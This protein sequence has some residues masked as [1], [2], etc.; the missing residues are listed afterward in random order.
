MG[1]NQSTHGSG[2]EGDGARERRTGVMKT[3]YY[4]L[5]GIE[6]RATEEEIKKAYRKKA[7]EL[8][9]DRNYD[10]VD[11]ATKLFAEIQA[12]YE[13]LSDPQERAWYDS[14]HD[15][16]LRDDDD[17]VGEHYEHNI[18]ITTAD[19]VLK[20]FTR[21]N[22]RIDFSDSSTGF[23]G[24]LRDTFD[25]LAN[26]EAAACDWEGLP[27]VEYPNF[28]HA[29]DS[30]ERVV[31]PFYA[32]WSAFATR[33][34]FAWK[35][36]FRCSEATE[37]RVRRVMEKENKR[38]REEGIRQF[39]DAVRSLVSFVRK[40]DPR[41]KS[42]MQTEAERQ[43]ILRDAATA[44]AIRSRAANR[45]R[46]GEHSVAEWSNYREP[47]LAEEESQESEIEEQHYECVAC[48]K[49][50]KSEKQFE[51]HE[52]SKKHLK[53]VQLLRKKMQKEDVTLDLDNE[54]NN[55]TK[56][57]EVVDSVPTT[58]DSDLPCDARSMGSTHRSPVNGTTADM[59][60]PDL[61]LD[62]ESQDA[63]YVSMNHDRSQPSNVSS[64]GDAFDDEYAPRDEVENRIFDGNGASGI[65]SMTETLSR[66]TMAEPPVEGTKVNSRKDVQDKPQ[67]QRVG[68][69]KE[70]R[71]KR[72]AQHDAEDQLGAEFTCAVCEAA[73]PSKTRLFRHIKDLDHA[74]P[75][76]LAARGG[77]GKRR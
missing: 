60:F 55:G 22:G 47:D 13:V 28:G 68:K 38:L 26:E 63:E 10:N 62:T 9:P 40:R 6:R 2:G 65:L 8:H 43:R 70:K 52:R 39:N 27:V 57:W 5:L 18:R 72:A 11:N 69:A 42:N 49:I 66:P 45:A 37:R 16:I 44:Q 31:R 48:H 41:Y 67:R 17:G 19:D 53:E 77:R 76:K 73:F 64:D 30:Y 1:A 4:E 75:I 25:S 35:D 74:Q 71:A 12:A 54:I 36:A 58:I 61:T 51:A 32:A 34:T 46:L 15:A 23:Y 50:F 56:A 59:S 29:E 20:M 3:C 21:F 24:V 14:H 33:K 7:L